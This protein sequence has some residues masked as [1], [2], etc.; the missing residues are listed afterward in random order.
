MLFVKTSSL[1][2]AV[3][4]SPLTLERFLGATC[5]CECGRTHT[6]NTREIVYSDEALGSI[7]GL[8][9][10]H[11][12]GATLTLVADRRTFA[13][14]GAACEATL[15]ADGFSIHRILVPD[16][17][18][19]EPICDDLTRD[20]LLA[21]L[22]P[23]DGFLAV[24]SGVINDLVK[25]MAADLHRPYIVVATAASMNGYASNNIAPAIR[26]VKQVINGTVPLAI[27]TTPALIAGAPQALTAA[28]LGD[29]LAKPVSL[30]DWTLNH[31]LFNEYYCPVCAQLIRDLEPSYLDHPDAILSQDPEALKA[32]FLALVYSGI[33]MTMAGTSFPA[34]GGEHM[35]SHVLDMK[36]MAEGHAHDYHG[37]QVGVGTIFACALYEQVLA[38]DR[39]D[40]REVTEPTDVDFW[41]SLT[42]VVEEEHGAKRKKVAL[43]VRQLQQPGV[44][45]AVRATLKPM[46]QPAP[47]IKDCLKRAAAAHTVSDIGCTRGQ[48]LDAV[49]HAH[50]MR[51]RYTILDLARAVGIL[52]RMAEDIIDTWLV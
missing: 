39:P 14:A 33:S 37:R 1:S 6:V 16:G 7:A 44:W 48:F 5:R 38:L 36:A 23:S 27:V 29:V 30:T 15:N 8:V 3:R 51:E 52:P 46:T 34:S 18:H 47:V 13:A 24:G 2:S 25:W 50:Q 10:R 12:P 9:R 20:A 22:P 43:A 4:F 19:G 17:P 49:L 40:F 45:D 42:P 21:T 28:G 41:G 11:M 32:L 26:G 31:L 35:M